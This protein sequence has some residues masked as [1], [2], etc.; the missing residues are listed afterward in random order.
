MKMV[1]SHFALSWVWKVVRG[2]SSAVLHQVNVQVARWWCFL[3]MMGDS[4]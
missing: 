1:D 2:C 3:K 4:Q